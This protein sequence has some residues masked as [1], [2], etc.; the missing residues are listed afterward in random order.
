MRQERISPAQ[1]QQAPTLP[2]VLDLLFPESKP[3]PG[4][5]TSR[6]AAFLRDLTGANAVILLGN[7]ADGPVATHAGEEIDEASARTLAARCTEQHAIY[8]EA[9]WLVCR[10]N[11]SPDATALAVLDLSGANRMALAL[12]HERL[13]LIRALCRSAAEGQRFRPTPG[14]LAQT[15]ALASGEWDGA[16][17]LVD[18]LSVALVQDDLGLARV[19]G[20]RAT[21]I[22]LAGQADI[23]KRSGMREEYRDR[24]HQALRTRKS[25][26]GVC[27]LGTPHSVALITPPDEPLPAAAIE[28]LQAV[29]PR[30][31][32]RTGLLKRLRRWAIAAL[33]LLAIAGGLSIP[34]DDTVNL[35]AQVESAEQRAVTVP[36]DGRIER[37]EVRDGDEI[38]AGQTVL[39]RMDTRDIDKQLTQFR[40]EQAVAISRREAA[41]GS[42]DAAAVREEE[43]NVELLTI[44]I[45]MESAKR[46]AATILSPIN[47]I[48]R[49]N[50][51]PDQ[52]GSFAGLGTKLMDVLDPAQK[53]LAVTVS[54]RVRARIDENAEGRFR[55]DADPTREMQFQL[56]SIALTPE[57]IDADTF[58]ARTRLLDAAEAKPAIVGMRGVAT[59]TVGNAPIAILLWNRLRDWAIL[60][61]W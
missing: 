7:A 56:A 36:F 24:V 34:I 61:F 4:D 8:T 58:A 51:G 39:A 10:L 17:A 40:T 37:I 27:F 20:H 35:P 44:R 42:R 48:V 33:V 22:L 3:S 57:G 60:T 9:S 23:S 14:I 25:D 30:R 19:E 26:P 21:E 54:P 59:F 47:G 12:A 41:R 31:A 43:L 28:V 11:T 53:R 16:Q 46:E 52:S 55:P 45:A 29:F 15:T 38:V 13:G 18:A 49:L 32:V 50:D 6:L 5:F 2:A 1:E